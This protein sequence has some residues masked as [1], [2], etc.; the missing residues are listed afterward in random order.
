M[1]RRLPIESLQPVVT[2]AAT[3]L[4]LALSALLS[5][6][7]LGFPYGGELAAVLGGV[8][9]P[10]A[11]A[12]L[13]LA[14]R[15]PEGALN[16]LVALGDLAVLMSIELVV[17]ETYGATRASALF[18][19]AVHAHFQGEWGG[20]ALALVGVVGLVVPSA[21]IEAGPIEGE[22]LAFYEAVFAVAALGTGVTVGRLRTSESASR[23]R[24]RE[25]T[26]HTMEAEREVR[27]EVAESIHDGPVQELIALDMTLSA[28]GQAAERREPE[29]A[30]ELIAEARE[31]AGRNVQALRDEIVDLG[32]YAFKELTYAMAVENCVQVWRRRY[33]LETRLVIEELD[34]PA[35]VASDLFHI[36]KEAVTNVGRHA[37]ARGVEVSLRALD[38]TLELRIA[39]DGEGFGDADPL[40]PVEPGHLGLASIRERVEL[41][42]GE[43]RIESSERGTKL[44]VMAP[45]SS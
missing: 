15:S 34:L 27:R 13:V 24:A 41:L 25:L 9:V 45:L 4:A 26:R 6:V 32:P 23:L 36:T 21:F 12:T 16:P 11:L 22:L 44:V 33:G 5:A 42:E 31:M 7:V 38:G 14:H 28:A 10:W 43:L 3:R 1:L 35:E 19:I 17:P 29:R 2:F 30:G 20:L 40:G 39:D 18:F 8:A 37:K